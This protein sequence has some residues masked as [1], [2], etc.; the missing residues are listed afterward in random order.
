MHRG[1]CYPSVRAPVCGKRRKYKENNNITL[2]DYVIKSNCMGFNEK[3][4]FVANID[5]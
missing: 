3:T 5:H 2:R 1:V 4:F